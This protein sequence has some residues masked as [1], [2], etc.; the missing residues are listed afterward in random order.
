MK[1]L[2]TLLVLSL[3][4][5]MS[6][7]KEELAAIADGTTPTDGSQTAAQLAGSGQYCELV[8]GTGAGGPYAVTKSLTLNADNTFA[9][10]VYFTDQTAC[11][12]TQNAG[13]EN[14]TSLF[15][16]GLWTVG[17]TNTTPSTGTKILFT[18]GA[19][20]VTVYAGAGPAQANAIDMASFLN[21]CSSIPA[22]STNSTS[23]RTLTGDTC[24]GG[25]GFTAVTLPALND[26]LNNTAYNN[27]TTNF[28]IGLSTAEDVWRPGGSNFPTAY[29]NTY[30]YW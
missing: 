23:S 3:F 6:C 4:L 10:T 8:S 13:G 22:F 30:Y 19:T 11:S 7:T 1:I 15:V 2:K 26:V 21:T 12:T 24:T 25:G 20:N 5:N 18:V 29:T 16:T 9:Y 28:Q 17:G 14:I 27:G